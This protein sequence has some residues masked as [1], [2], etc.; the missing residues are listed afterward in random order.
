MAN[1]WSLHP[2]GPWAEIYRWNG[3]ASVDAIAGLAERLWVG[4]F[5][6]LDLLAVEELAE[7]TGLDDHELTGDRWWPTQRAA[8]RLADAGHHAVTVPSAALPGTRNLVLL[9]QRLA[10]SFDDDPIDVI[11]VPC[12]VAAE[13]SHGVTAVL[14]AVRHH[15]TA[16]PDVGYRALVPTPR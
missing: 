15:G 13:G 14:D 16:F 6:H 8:G 4:R 3:L 1:Y 5:E 2:H 10:I 7:V 12:A 11:D 9:G